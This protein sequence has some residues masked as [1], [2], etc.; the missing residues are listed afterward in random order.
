M[1]VLAAFSSPEPQPQ[2]QPEILPPERSQQS[3]ASSGENSIPAQP[4]DFDKAAAHVI[5]EN[6]AG[7]TAGAVAGEQ[8]PAGEILRSPEYF[9]RKAE[10]IIPKPFRMMAVALDCP[11]LELDPKIVAIL[12][13]DGGLAL[14]ELWPIIGKLFEDYKYKNCMVFGLMFSLLTG[15]KFLDAWKLFKAKQAAE[16]TEVKPQTF[17]AK[18]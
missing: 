1:K 17:D 16:K 9:R 11:S 7:A 2:A 13:D 6:G 12:A 3:A 15:D 5:A 8:P 10:A 14:E 18:T 4:D